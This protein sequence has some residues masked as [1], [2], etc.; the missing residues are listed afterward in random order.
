MDKKPSSTDKKNDPKKI[1]RRRGNEE[2]VF[3]PSL[4]SLSYEKLDAAE[5]PESSAPN[6][7][8]NLRLPRRKLNKR[9]RK[10]RPAELPEDIQKK[11]Q[12]GE[13]PTIPL[14]PLLAKD[15]QMAA[16]KRTPKTALAQ[17]TTTPKRRGRPPKQKSATDIRSLLNNPEKFKQD[18]NALVDLVRKIDQTPLHAGPR[19]RG[20][21]PKHA[22]HL[23]SFFT[24]ETAPSERS[25]SVQHP[26]TSSPHPS[27]HSASALPAPTTDAKLA[28]SLAQAA[29]QSPAPKKRGRPKKQ[30][31][32]PLSSASVTFSD[33]TSEHPTTP[34]SSQSPPVSSQLP[35]APNATLSSPSLPEAP[36]ATLSSPSLSEAPRK[37]GRPKKSES[38]HLIAPSAPLQKRG[39]GRPRKSESLSS[40]HSVPAASI[41]TSPSS[42]GYHALQPITTTDA[43]T[44]APKKRGPGRPKKSE[45]LVQN[46]SP[47]PLQ[48]RG[49]GRPRKT[50]SLVSLPA[51]SNTLSSAIVSAVAEP[52]PSTNYSPSADTL[53]QTHEAANNTAAV[54]AETPPKR[55]RGRPRKNPIP[56]P[57]Q[58]TSP[59]IKRGPGRPRKIENLVAA[60]F[61]DAPK[62]R[63][64]G[65][66]RKADILQRQR[67]KS[68]QGVGP[69]QAITF[70]AL[71]TQ[72]EALQAW[73]NKDETVRLRVRK[74]LEGSA[75]RTD[76]SDYREVIETL[77]FKMLYPEDHQGE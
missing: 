20:R 25:S 24:N 17:T 75:K 6:T 47:L 32:S 54:V 43:A 9:A 70:R 22:T 27:S 4:E 15:S 50:E 23:R 5:N 16:K 35:Q 1:L 46:T 55:G 53:A 34:S 8:S 29:T 39:R 49:R 73:R 72:L 12:E 56:Q 33:A 10:V 2:V 13:S 52:S 65:R 58:H 7:S 68:L 45:S 3:D 11:I 51:I 61:K 31:D 41:Q 71:Q 64:P 67:K 76:D 38:I 74:A 42:V 26:T 36:N 60:V 59:P 30:V 66:P 37:R 69:G 18:S 48:K 44:D 40:L 63:G 19:K 57:S 21:P 28:A 14:S 62:K 77:I